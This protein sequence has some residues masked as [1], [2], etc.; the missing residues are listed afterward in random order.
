MTPV[1][2]PLIGREHAAG[3]LHGEISRVIDSHGGLV[4]VAGEAG[5]G[6]TTLVTGAAVEARRRGALVLSGSCWESGGAPGHWPWMQVVRG[7]RRACTAEEWAALEDA[8]DGALAVLLGEHPGQ[9][10]GADE[11]GGFVLYDGV[12]TALVSASQRRPLMVVLDDLHWADT[13]SVRLLEF[14]AQHT[15]FERLLLVGTYRDVEVEWAEHPLRPL[16]SSLVTRAT[17]VTLT[18]LDRAE[19]GELMA[20]T[21]GRRPDDALVAEVHR[22]TG[23]NPFF[24]EQAARLW[25]GGSPV[26]AIAPGV[27]DAVQRRLSLLPEPVVRLLTTAAVLG[28]EF[29]RRLLAAVAAEPAAH[30]DRLLDQAVAARLAVTLGGGRFAF[31]HDLVRETLYDTL[32]E[33]AA[34]RRHAEVVRAVERSA[35]LAGDV[36]PAELARHAHLARDVLEP[37]QVVDRLLDAARHASSRLSVEESLGHWRRALEAAAA[38]GP[39]RQALIALDMTR[40]LYH[41]GESEQAWSVLRTAVARARESGDP[42]VLARVALS[43]Y[44][45][46]HHGRQEDLLPEAHRALLGED[47]DVERAPRDRL[48]RELTL[49]TTALARRERDDNLLA[50]TLWTMHDLIWGP[51]TA[52]ER[53]RL[54]YE[55]SALA[56]RGADPDMTAM[57]SSLRW[58]ALLEQGDPRYL[59]ALDAFVTVAE[60]E[61]LPRLK[62]ATLVDRSII[63]GLQGRFEEADGLLEEVTCFGETE[64]GDFSGMLH[65]LRWALLM[66]QGRTDELDGLPGQRP[67]RDGVHARLLEGITALYRDDLGTALRHLEA[68][69]TSGKPISGTYAPLWLRFQ[70]Q[71][72]AATR[73]P[74]LCE[75]A[76]AALTPYVDQWAVS[77]YGCDISGPYRLWLA[78]VDAAQERWDEAVAGFTAAAVSADR[79]GAHPWAIEAR[80]GLAR[81]LAARGSSEAAAALLDEVERDAAE[82]GMRHIVE[83][84]RRA[85]ERPTPVTDHGVDVNE[86]RFDGEVWSLAYAGRL[87]H[88]PD[89]K[90]LRDLHLLLSR[91]GTDVPASRLANPEGGREAAAAR[92]LGGDAV[93]DEEAKTRY[94]RRLA[95]LD[96]E[97]DRAVA[98]GDDDRAAACDRERAALLAELRAAAGLAGRTRRLGDEAERARKTVTARIRDTLRR[99]DH[100]HPE[101]AAHLRASV[102]TGTTCVYRPPHEISWR[103]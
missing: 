65:H 93:L 95:E 8:A 4:L 102:S 67:S 82:L 57:A 45:H 23:G 89:A 52:A 41:C 6:K 53:E 13:A 39:G 7:L 99:L 37:A 50:F 74:E 20:R 103:L 64:H 94:K 78:M 32:D 97:I 58:V 31:A 80:A 27:R 77:V 9:T 92:A 85:R 100:R 24:V 18:G 91:P 79:L 11:P 28:R 15:W 21:V 66:L 101:L 54:T 55:L 84:A 56:D 2:P 71:V 40:E 60:R 83:R 68:L 46:D 47:R 44:L 16:I 48:A 72:A 49:H 81:S 26:D 1:T 51:G 12:T 30:V 43:L 88:M 38:L 17:V 73:D 22:R 69:T 98:L 42:A 36:Q 10:P 59:D 63:A 25:H 5:I 3:M 87:V 62:V 90:G 33:A 86:F 96:E 61:D 34:A 70:A 75:R 35:D 76:R 19:V 14:A 29:H